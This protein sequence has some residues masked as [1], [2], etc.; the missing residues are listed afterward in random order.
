MTKFA[1][2][3][4]IILT[5]P[6]VFTFCLPAQIKA[7]DTSFLTLKPDEAYGLAK[8]DSIPKLF[9]SATEKLFELGLPDP[10]EGEY[11]E[12]EIKT[13]SIWGG[14]ANVK[15]H[16]WVLPAKNKERFGI[17]WNGVVYPVVSVGEKKDF[18]SDMLAMISTDEQLRA[19]QKKENPDFPFSRWQTVLPN[20]FSASHE[21]MVPL[22]AALLLKLGERELAAKVSDTWLAGLRDSALEDAKR[23][24][25]FLMLAV[26]WTW[27]LFD[28]AL[29]AH[30]YGDDEN[31]LSFAGFLAS[32]DG[33]IEAEAEKRGFEKPDPNRSKEKAPYLDFLKPLG[34]LLVDQKRRAGASKT[35]IPANVIK[36]TG[37]PEKR[38]QITALISK[39]DEIAERQWGQPGGVSLGESPI[40]TALVS[41]GDDAVEPLLRVLETDDRLTRSVSFH[42]DFFPSRHIITVSE[43][44]YWALTGILKTTAFN[45][46]ENYV[47]VG[48]AE[49]R[50]ELAARIRA[51]LDKYGRNTG[52][53]RWY[54][55]L[56][57]DKASAEEWTQAA[58]NIISPVSSNQIWTN[59]R[60]F[61]SAPLPAQR[62]TGGITLQGEQLRAKNLP[63]VSELFARRMFELADRKP[64]GYHS[65][66]LAATNLALALLVWDGRE[67]LSTVVNFQNGIKKRLTE[68]SAPLS[69]DTS[70][71]LRSMLLLLYLKRCEV[72][73]ADAFT[74]Y[75]DWV[76]TMSPAEAG[77]NTLM[78]FM[79][80]W[81][82]ANHPAIRAAANRL[83]GGAES[84]AWLPLIDG[85]DRQSF[86][87][88]K[89][90]ESPLLN[91]KSFRD[92]AIVGLE[93]KTVVGA[94]KPCPVEAT[95]GF[96][97]PVEN[98]F[99]A[100]M[101]GAKNAGSSTISLNPDD[102]RMA[103]PIGPINVRV[104]DAYASALTRLEG[105]PKFNISWTEK[106]RDS[107]IAELKKFLSD[108]QKRFESPFNTY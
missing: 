15:I 44:A 107:S 47:D 17:G 82:Y 104:C 72:E 23:K 20:S 1:Y 39:M 64:E 73:D 32:L 21:S 56:A 92:A 9:L 105:A 4:L 75:A 54:T 19:K 78:L 70:A 45:S 66:L 99:T 33:K 68:A 11:R 46:S 85:A 103:R 59:S 89:L 88:A 41:Q 50:R 65:D 53:E 24:D 63:S 61:T 91:V 40:V 29:T 30:M 6:A 13:G 55:I 71:S 60:T 94:L 25:P 69:V 51:Y 3:L 38:A 80:M 35:R 2:L 58:A 22:K 57:D 90:L 101:V 5:G 62:K 26:D 77:E 18:R 16:G 28:A 86:D 34:A 8:K 12:L 96:T 100:V 43:A 106:E 81:R 74:E 84:S 76:T 48:T 27:A 83:F 31:A 67:Q 108:T 95:E 49:G 10:R 97:L 36:T 93:N 87:R 102:K 52:E 42:R 98:T 7:E 14:S 37:N 79:P